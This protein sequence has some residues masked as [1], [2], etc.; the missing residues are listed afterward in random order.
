MLSIRTLTSQLQV[1]VTSSFLIKTEQNLKWLTSSLQHAGIRC[2]L[3]IK[4]SS[5]SSVAPA[6]PMSETATDLRIQPYC[7]SITPVRFLFFAF[8]IFP[9]LVLWCDRKHPKTSSE[10]VHGWELKLTSNMLITRCLLLFP[11][12]CLMQLVQAVVVYYIR[13]IYI[14]KRVVSSFQTTL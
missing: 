2:M 14:S 11:N 9:P 1:Q 10:Y 3:L 4:L 5:Y 6:D 13:A 12:L 8:P 7:W